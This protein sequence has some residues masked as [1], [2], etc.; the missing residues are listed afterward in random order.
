MTS[1]IATAMTASDSAVAG[2][3]RIGYV[4]LNW[5][6]GWTTSHTMRLASFSKEKQIEVVEKDLL[7][8]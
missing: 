8:L 3:V 1:F 6:N 7:H 5:T 2:T 4:G